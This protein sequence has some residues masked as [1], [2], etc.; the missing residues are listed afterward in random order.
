MPERT[1]G[2]FTSHLAAVSKILHVGSIS[3][4]VDLILTIL[5]GIPRPNNCPLGPRPQSGKHCSESC[6]CLWCKIFRRI[7]CTSNRSSP[8]ACCFQARL[9]PYTVRPGIQLQSTCGFK[10]KTRSKRPQRR[11]GWL[12]CGCPSRGSF[13]ARKGCTRIQTDE[14]QHGRVD[15]AARTL[16]I[17][18]RFAG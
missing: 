12:G 16:E 15:Q 17:Q 1:K 4:L 5:L 8:S 9:Q 2:Y 10:I 13:A 3:K 11:R 14:G 18:W 7:R 6:R